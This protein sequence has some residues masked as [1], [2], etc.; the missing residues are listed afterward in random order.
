[1]HIFKMS[2]RKYMKRERE[3]RGRKINDNKVNSWVNKRGI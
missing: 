3:R 1:M 2:E